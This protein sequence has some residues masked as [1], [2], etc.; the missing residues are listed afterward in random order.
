MEV[1]NKKMSEFPDWYTIDDKGLDSLNYFLKKEFEGKTVKI[2]VQEENKKS[3]NS[4]DFQKI[5]LSHIKPS[6]FE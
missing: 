5:V 2:I 6:F 4:I 1:K 3:E